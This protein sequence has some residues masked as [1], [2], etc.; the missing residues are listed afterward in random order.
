M[1]GTIQSATPCT[2]HSTQKVHMQGR[3]GW[4]MVRNEHRLHKLFIG[5]DTQAW[6]FD[7]CSQVMHAPHHLSEMLLA[8]VMH[9]DPAYMHCSYRGRYLADAGPRRISYFKEATSM[10]IAVRAGSRELGGINC[11]GKSLS[12]SKKKLTRLSHGSRGDD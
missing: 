2:W 4:G 6:G 11:H 9:N 12:H 1:E 5:R 3:C 10:A 8:V 7:C